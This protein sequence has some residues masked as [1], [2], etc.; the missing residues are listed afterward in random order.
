LVTETLPEATDILSKNGVGEAKHGP[1]IA[2]PERGTFAVE[3]AV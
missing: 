3:Q 2:S 1:R